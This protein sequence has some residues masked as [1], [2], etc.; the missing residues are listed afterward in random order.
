MAGRG[1]YGQQDRTGAALAQMADMA[2]QREM[3]QAQEAQAEKERRSRYFAALINA[4]PAHAHEIMRA[5]PDAFSGVNYDP[6]QFTPTADERFKG[7]VTQDQIRQFPGLPQSVRQAG[8]Y[9]GAYGAAMPKEQVEA[10]TA[11]D[12]YGNKSSF[13]PEMQTRQGIMDGTVMNADQTEKA[14]Q[15]GVELEEI[16]KPES[17]ERVN[18]TRAQ[19]GLVGA[20][21]GETNAR[22]GLVGEQTTN[23]REKRNPQSP[24]SPAYPKPPAPTAAGGEIDPVLARAEAT[25]RQGLDSAKVAISGVQ[26]AINDYRAAIKTGKFDDL[27][28][29]QANL[30]R[31]TAGAKFTVGAMYGQTGQRLSDKDVKILEKIATPGF[32]IGMSSVK[33]LE[34]FTRRNLASIDVMEKKSLLDY[35]PRRAQSAPA[36][37]EM[38]FDAKGNRIK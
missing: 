2:R 24:V 22:T 3:M 5:N 28:A 13:A 12:V 11:N 23:E 29:A 16:K 15:W 30:A 10:I 27:A 7:M 19:T 4:N 18:L 8:T 31:A 9:Q 32:I 26:S 35:D 34:D 21:T 20:Q 33:A 6:S 14:R 17:T 1:F 38:H 37:T 36:D 25:R